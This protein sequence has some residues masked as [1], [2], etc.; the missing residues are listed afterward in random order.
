[1]EWIMAITPIGNSGYNYFP[2]G[3]NGATGKVGQ[4]GK[5]DQTDFNKPCQT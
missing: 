3:L 5:T 1:M 4:T 2:A